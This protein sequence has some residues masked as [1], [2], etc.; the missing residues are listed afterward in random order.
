MSASFTFLISKQSNDIIV[1]YTTDSSDIFKTGHGLDSMHAFISDALSSNNNVELTFESDPW[2]EF[3]SEHEDY[4][5]QVS[6][7]IKAIHGDVSVEFKPNP[8]P[9]G[10]AEY[11]DDSDNDDEC[12][13]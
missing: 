10:W 9:A 13:G 6:I 2:L 3:D 1:N 5:E 7:G 4:Q 11:V 8:L 12:Y